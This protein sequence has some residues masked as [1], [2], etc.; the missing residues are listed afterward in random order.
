MKLSFTI[1]LISTFHNPA[2]SPSVRNKVKISFILK[3]QDKSFTE[4]P[5]R[6]QANIYK[7]EKSWS[8]HIRHSMIGL[9][10][11]EFGEEGG[12]FTM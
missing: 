7:K 8:F 2:I 4:C 6:I 11:N 3:I 10:L 1:L 5:L 12:R 9:L